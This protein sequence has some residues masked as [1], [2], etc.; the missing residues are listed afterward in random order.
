MQILF[1]IYDKKMLKR[2]KVLMRE[3]QTDRESQNRARLCYY[4]GFEH[5]RWVMSYEMWATSKN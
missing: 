4:A 1:Q 3:K 2:K 5:Q